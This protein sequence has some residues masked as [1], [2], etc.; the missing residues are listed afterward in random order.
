MIIFLA[1]QAS[2][3]S[4]NRHI[5]IPNVSPRY[6]ISV[7]IETA[8]S[9]SDD[10]IS[11]LAAVTITSRSTGREIQTIKLPSLTLF[12]GSYALGVG[13]H[14]QSPSPYGDT[15]S[16]VF[17]DFDFD[18]HQDLA[19]C[20]DTSGG[21]GSPAYDV[22]RWNVARKKFVKDAFLSKLSS[23]RLGLIVTDPTHRELISFEKDGAA[24]HKAST[25]RWIKRK[26][27]LVKEE[28]DDATGDKEVITTKTIVGANWKTIVRRL[29]KS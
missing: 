7:D 15:F 1:F 28:I 12:K 16:F 18:G 10:P 23:E 8:E 25:Y 13:P 19:I 9:G 3:A 29:S 2:I 22:F 24:W 5:S 11:G 26:L 17:Q 27:T 14:D 4:H 21:Y 6:S 20:K